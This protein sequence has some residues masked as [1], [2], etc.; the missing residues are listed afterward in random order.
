HDPE[1]GEWKDRKT[2]KFSGGEQKT[3][4]MSDSVV[5][6]LPSPKKGTPF[7]GAPIVH[8][9]VVVDLPSGVQGACFSPNGHLYVAC[10]VRL[11]SNRQYKAI[12]YFSALNGH[13]MGIIPVLAEEENQELEGICFGNVVSTNGNPAQIHAILLENRTLALD[14]IF[15]KS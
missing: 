3:I 4:V 2:L 14:N 5:A 10:D 15:L 7:G 1:T 9:T 12:A 6:G 8:N 11:T 13:L